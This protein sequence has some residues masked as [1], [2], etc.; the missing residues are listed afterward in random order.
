MA[1]SLPSEDQEQAI[2][3]EWLRRKGYKH[4]RVPSETFTRSWKQKAKNKRLGVVRG[5]P[6]LFVFAHG[7]S[8]AIEMKRKSR[9]AKATPEQREWLEFLAGYG[10]ASAVCHGADEAMQFVNEVTD[11]NDK[12]STGRKK[13]C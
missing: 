2:F 7:K 3:V 9:S 5:V 12:L 6:D 1:T 4:F 11:I 13:N 10:F 8:M